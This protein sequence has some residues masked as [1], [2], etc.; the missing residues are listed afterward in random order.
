M[1]TIQSYINLAFVVAL[2]LVGLDTPSQDKY[3]NVVNK[4]MPAC[5]DIK[6]TGFVLV[7]IA[8]FGEELRISELQIKTVEGSGVFF[9]KDGYIITVA[10]LFNL[11]TKIQTVDV[12]SP[13]GN[14]VF[15]RVI[16][17]SKGVDLAVIKVDF[18][19]KTPYVKLA[20]P[21]TLKVGQEVIAI[22]SPLGMTFSVTNGIISALYR[23]IDQV[24]YNVTQSNTAINPG[25]SGGPLFNL[26]GELV[27]VNS[28]MIPPVNAPIFTG[29]GFSV[30][31]GQVLE[32]ITK[33]MKNETYKIQQ[34]QIQKTRLHNNVRP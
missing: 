29:L 27:G 4:V 21:R 5:V 9:N 24:A 23:D 11:F 17:V 10:H 19:D 16:K 31:S 13:D 30:Q 32:F 2:L 22:G 6:V 34:K 33:V 15:G 12:E 28:F 1:K 8:V 25:N 14:H 3:V 18:Y 20:D 7:P 26:K